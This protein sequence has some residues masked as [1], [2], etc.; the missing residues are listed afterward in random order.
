MSII[1]D[2]L[3]DGFFSALAAI[4]FSAVSN[5]PRVA[6]KWCGLIAAL[7]HVTRYC[8][9][10]FTPAGIVPASLAGALVVGVLAVVIG[11]RL[12]CPPE[13]FSYPALLPMIPGIYAYRSMQGFVMALSAASEQEFSHYFYV[14][15]SNFVTC[16]FVILCMVIGQMIPALVF[17]R[18][19]YTATKG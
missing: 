18:L 14:C 2:I 19:T 10:T 8:L 16:V 1:W 12:K 11:P 7:G 13:T 3:S 9:M 17:K 4:G 15:Q 5:P 6:L